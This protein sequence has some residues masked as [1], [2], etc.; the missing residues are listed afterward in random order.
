LRGYRLDNKDNR[1]QDAE[2]V[3]D[4]VSKRGFKVILDRYLA[5]KHNALADLT[6]EGLADDTLKARQVI[7]NQ[8]CE[9]INIPEEIIEE[10]KVA[11]EELKQDGD[12]KD[13]FIKGSVPFVGRR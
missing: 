12:R 7:Y 1:I 11:V 6:N 2:A 3:R 10:G 5:V 13:T 9:W 8:I 4:I